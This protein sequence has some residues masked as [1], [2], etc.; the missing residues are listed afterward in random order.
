MTLSFEA[1]WSKPLVADTGGPLH[2]QE[3]RLSRAAGPFRRSGGSRQRAR[4]KH[5]SALKTPRVSVLAARSA[6]IE[7]ARSPVPITAMVASA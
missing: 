5:H 4:K 3:R 7:L 2:M 1:I 6:G